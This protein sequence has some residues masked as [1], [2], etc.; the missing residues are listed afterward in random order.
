[1]EL[2]K[3][4]RTSF[5]LV[6]ISSN[7]NPLESRRIKSSFLMNWSF[8]FSGWMFLVLEARTFIEYT[9]A[10]YIASALTVV[11]ISFTIVIFHIQNIF[12][13]IEECEKIVQTGKNQINQSINCIQNSSGN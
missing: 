4:L 8:S 5:A 10:I 9:S 11:A 2:F 6:G 7:A 12:E 1:M 13:F 3:T